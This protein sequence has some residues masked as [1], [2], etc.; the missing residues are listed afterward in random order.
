MTANPN[1]TLSGWQ[2]F[3]V[4]FRKYADFSGRATRS[5]FW[6]FR[7]FLLLISWVGGFVIGFVLGAL[8]GD[9]LLASLGAQLIIAVANLVFMLPILSSFSRRLHDIGLSGW[10]QALFFVPIVNIVAGVILMILACKD[11]EPGA[12]RFGENPK[13]IPW[14]PSAGN[15]TRMSNTKRVEEDGFAQK[16]YAERYW[17]ERQ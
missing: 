10:W 12:N 11:S 17:E 13:G 15:A 3:L 14:V 1:Q 5:E 6:Y 4:A 8:T 9:E 2:W 7:L 16:T